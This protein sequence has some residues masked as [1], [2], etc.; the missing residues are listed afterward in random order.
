MEVDILSG[1]RRAVKACTMCS[2]Y[3]TG[4]AC[5]ALLVAGCGNGAK[6]GGT[7]APTPTSLQVAGARCQGGRCAC[8]RVDDT[9]RTMEAPDADEGAIAEGQKRFEIR[10]GRGLNPLSL[11]I[12]GRG[13]LTKSTESPEPSCAYIDLPPGKHTVHLKATASNPDAG[14]EPA[15][16]IS[17]YSANKKSWYDTFAL[18]CGGGDGV[19]T[20]GH[21]QQWI[22]KV[23]AQPRGIFDPCGSV[24]VQG[25]KWSGQRSVGTILS[26]VEVDLTLEVY[27]FAPR[28]VHGAPTCKGPSD[29]TTDP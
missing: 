11:T 18:R 12:A 25:I 26:D 3:W 15:F 14:Q 17:E 8:R 13:T 7:T 22:D 6:G 20:Q 23:Q 27:K 28:F 5:A 10:T 29:Q 19:C 4:L 9:N 2:M 24:R 1:Y 16:F 21:M